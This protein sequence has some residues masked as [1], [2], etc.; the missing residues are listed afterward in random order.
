MDPTFKLKH[1]V[2]KPA[3]TEEQKQRR[4]EDARK[5]LSETESYFK[6]IVYIDEATVRLQPKRQSFLGRVGEEQLRTDIRLKRNPG[7]APVIGFLLAACMAKGL[8][9]VKFLA[10]S[11][12][13]EPKR[14]YWVST[15]AAALTSA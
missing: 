5:L 12:G 14:Q 4:V 15:A 1:E 9:G 13:F 8:V 3:F 2:L 7:K 10:K 6:G 11:T